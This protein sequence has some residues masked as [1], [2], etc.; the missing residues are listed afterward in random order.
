MEHEHFAQPFMSWLWFDYALEDSSRIVDRLL[1][2]DSGLSAGE[3]RYLQ[4]MRATSMRL[5]EV[6]A[7]APGES[8]TLRDVVTGERQTVR[9]RLGS[10]Q[11]QR[12]DMLA[13]RVAPAGASGPPEIEDVI[14]LPRLGIE[15][16]VDELRTEFAEWRTEEPDT[17]DLEFFEVV[18]PRLHR[19][20]L[21]AMLTPAHPTVIMPDGEQA[22][23]TTVRFEVRDAAVVTT[24]LARARDMEQEG[25]ERCWLWRPRR[26]S[27]KEPPV[28]IR[29]HRDTLLVEA[30][31]RGSAERAGARIE[32]LAGTA[33]RRGLA[34]HQDLAQAQA[35]REQL[36]EAP[37]P[38]PSPPEAEDLVLEHYERHYASWLDEEI[39]ALDGRTPRQAA[40]SAKL[41]PR[42]IDL[43]K[44][45]EHMYTSSLARGQ[46]GYDPMWM[47]EEIGLAEASEA[48]PRP[49]HPPPLGHES[50]ARLV[51]GLDVLACEV[52]DR[53]RSRR[54]FAVDTIVTREALQSDVGVRRFLLDHARRALASG[55]DEEDAAM[56][57]DLVGA[58]LEYLCNYELHRRKTFWVEDGLAWMLGQTNLDIVGE[59]LRVPFAS[60]ALVF[61]DRDT[62]GLAERLLSKQASCALR[63][64]ILKVLTAYVTES[65][66]EGTRGLRLA[67][68]FDDVSADWPYLLSRD[69][70]V[71]PDSHLEAILE[72]HLPDVDPARRDP[73]F[74]DPLFKRLMQRVLNAILYATSA[75]AK[76]DSRRAPRA[77]PARGTSPPAPPDSSAEEVYFLPGHIDIREVRQLQRAQRVPS[78]RALVHRFM[79]RGHWRRASPTWKDQRLRWV[80]PY[81]KGPDI[82]SVV[83]RAYRL[84]AADDPPE[85]Q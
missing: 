35:M 30:L 74:T 4:D 79:V 56:D 51:P 22:L 43:I 47:W 64:R 28:T 65:P 85:A 10:R 62:L 68:T 49:E 72:S 38:G 34:T 61:T 67:F 75:G 44:G 58:H 21:Q 33:V 42:L 20:W 15:R 69:L 76:V 78:G 82:A 3:R 54:G 41:R 36:D 39:P 13:V 17:D 16:H 32:R 84:G 23:I 8:V 6:D 9:E 45:L 19:I 57:A 80:Q 81:W 52:A 29:L 40:R 53:T 2:S 27:R 24:A 25:E 48:P 11:M 83:E 14:P 50:M 1:A 5:Y 18:A 55:L 31:T 60:F 71:E 7:V 73:V 46:V 26:K 37:S 77:K 66:G 70:L 63:G 12:W 59:A